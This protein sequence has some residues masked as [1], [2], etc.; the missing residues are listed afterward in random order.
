MSTTVVEVVVDTQLSNHSSQPSLS[1]P[2]DSARSSLP[3]KSFLRQILRRKISGNYFVKGRFV[4]ILSIQQRP[5]DSKWIALVSLGDG[6]AQVDSLCP[7]SVGLCL[8]FSSFFF[9]FVT[10]RDAIFWYDLLESSRRKMDLGS[11][12]RW[13]WKMCCAVVLW[14]GILS[15]AHDCHRNDRSLFW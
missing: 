5:Q 2:I 1:Q 10:T 6:S 3:I 11:K 14:V 4:R 12:C 9:H 7:P 15:G 8:I 13:K